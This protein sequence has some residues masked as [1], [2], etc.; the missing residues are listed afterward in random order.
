[1][2]SLLL[3]RYALPPVTPPYNV[4]RYRPDATGG[5]SG[6]GGDEGGG[7]N[8][9]GGKDGGGEGGGGDGGGGEGGGDG[10]AERAASTHL[11]RPEVSSCPWR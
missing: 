2:P 5:V 1:M 11:C 6:E 3:D 10:D 9:V 7:S 4:I 8:G